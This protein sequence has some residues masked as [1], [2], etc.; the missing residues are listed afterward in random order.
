M[1]LGDGFLD[2]RG[3]EREVFRATGEGWMEMKMEMIKKDDFV[4]IDN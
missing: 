3:S 1:R 2:R 4:E